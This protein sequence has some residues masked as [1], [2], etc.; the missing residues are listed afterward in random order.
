[1]ALFA[2]IDGQGSIGTSAL[3]PLFDI[4]LRLAVTAEV[5][6]NS[7]RKSEGHVPDAI[8]YSTVNM[9]VGTRTI[10]QAVAYPE[11]SRKSLK[12]LERARRIE[13]PT[14]TLA[15]LC[16]TPELRPRSR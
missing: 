11:R 15:R 14:L 1:M 7:G 8:A 13:R 16:S 5:E 4:R 2:T 10:Q 9:E 3:K 6:D 12:K